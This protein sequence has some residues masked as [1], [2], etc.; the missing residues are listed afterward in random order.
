MLISSAAHAKYNEE[1]NL[2]TEQENQIKQLQADE[3]K[4]AQDMKGR[5]KQI[6]EKEKKLQE[7][8]S[9]YAN[10]EAELL[11]YEYFLPICESDV[12]RS[13]PIFFFH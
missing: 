6:E 9:D 12:C 13:F 2:I 5:T 7:I 8:Q 1:L 10:R 4:I 3:K 11:R